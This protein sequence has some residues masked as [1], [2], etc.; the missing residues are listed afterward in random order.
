MATLIEKTHS[1]YTMRIVLDIV[2]RVLKGVTRR[3]RVFKFTVENRFFDL[4]LA[5]GEKLVDN[6]IRLSV[7]CFL[8]A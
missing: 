6:K 3:W 8:L 1:V 5:L 2:K 7:A 4:L